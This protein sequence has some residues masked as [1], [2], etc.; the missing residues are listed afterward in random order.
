V[1]VAVA[2]ALVRPVVRRHH[3]DVL[4]YAPALGRRVVDRLVR[5]VL[6][7]LLGVDVGDVRAYVI[8]EGA[9]LFDTVICCTYRD[10]P[11]KREW[12]GIMTEGPRLSRRWK[13]WAMKKGASIVVF[14]S[15]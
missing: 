14:E 5:V 10:Y 15:S 13:P 2:H 7:E 12:G 3:R 6:L 11:Y 4:G 1:Q 8:N 9:L